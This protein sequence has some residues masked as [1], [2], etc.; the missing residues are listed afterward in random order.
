[1]SESARRLLQRELGEQ[2]SGERERWSARALA[3]AANILSGVRGRTEE[4]RRRFLVERMGIDDPDESGLWYQQEHIVRL[5]S[6]AWLWS[7]MFDEGRMR[8]RTQFAEFAEFAE[9]HGDQ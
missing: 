4:E 6:R 3:T 8:A 5:E 9:E 7:L 1:L 2:L